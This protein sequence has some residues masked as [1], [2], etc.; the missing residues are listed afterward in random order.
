[1][2]TLT[3]ARR[4]ELVA[5]AGSW[6]SRLGMKAPA[7]L[8]LEFYKPLSFLGAQALLFFQPVLG[9]WVGDEVVRDYAALLEEPGSVERLVAQLEK[10][11]Q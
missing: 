8:L 3:D 1:M 7:I 4:D 2:S 10:G 11:E 6:I 5:R 9:A